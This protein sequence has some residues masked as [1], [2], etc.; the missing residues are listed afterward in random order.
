M[1]PN[2]KFIDAIKNYNLWLE[3]AISK[4]RVRFI[5]T[6]LGPIWEV[7]GTLIF[8]IFISVVWS[9]LWKIPFIEFFLYLYPGFI[10]WKAI[11]SVIVDGTYLFSDTYS[12]HFEN[13][14]VHPIVFCLAHA[15]KNFIVLLFSFP[16]VL[17]I[18]FYSGSLHVYTLILIPFF[19]L[20][21]FITSVAVTFIIATFCLKYR[22]LQ[23][24]IAVFL[25]LAFFITPVIW[26]V[27]QLGEKSQRFLIEPNLIYHYIEFFRSSFINGNVNELSLNIVII[28][29]LLT[30]LIA[31]ITY[32]FVKNKLAF[33]I[34]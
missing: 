9:K 13:V 29:T 19:L 18:V 5:R 32:K 12:S 6:A 31:F 7:L 26:Q 28:T 33:W 11:Y 14:K 2:E 10:I 21:F 15:A 17:I 22:D 8:L 34:T 24:S 3:M 20:L 23:F 27:E 4:I 16:I 25:S 30:C 1:N